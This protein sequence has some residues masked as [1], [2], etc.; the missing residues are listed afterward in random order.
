MPWVMFSYGDKVLVNRVLGGAVEVGMPLWSQSKSLGSSTWGDGTHNSGLLGHGTEI[1]ASCSH[2]EKDLLV[3]WAMGIIVA[4]SKYVMRHGDNKPRLF[5]ECVDACD[6]ICKVACG[7]KLT[8]A[9][10]T[11]GRVYT[12]G[13]SAYGQLGSATANGKLPTRVEGKIA[14]KFVEEIACGS[15]HVAVDFQNKAPR[16]LTE[17]S[18]LSV[19]SCYQAES[20]NFKHE[21]KL[22]SQTRLLFPVQ[23]GNFHLRGFYSPKM[24]ICPVRDSKNILPASISSSKRT[25]GEHLLLQEC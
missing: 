20:R 17:V 2:L 12:V 3:L 18:R 24:P 7:Y 21:L 10:T 6:K 4:L 13:S 16:L 19:D 8:V 25:S 15:Y 23:N 11:S 22:E 9:L 1:V 14:Y 5:P